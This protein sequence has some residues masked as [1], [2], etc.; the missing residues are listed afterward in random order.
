MLELKNIDKKV[1]NN[2]HIKDVSLNQRN[3]IIQKIFDKEVS[4]NVHFKP[5]PLLSAYKNRGYE[6]DSYP[7]A[8]ALWETEI[9]LPIYFDLDE[10][11]VSK[12]IRA[13]VDSYNEVVKC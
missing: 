11:K 7:M 5:L 8:N 2:F 9:S 3:E 6:I 10:E 1:G 4:V 13:V 12:V